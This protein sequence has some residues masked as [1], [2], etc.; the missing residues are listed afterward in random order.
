M[1]A[2]IGAEPDCGRFGNK[3]QGYC[4]DYPQPISQTES[5]TARISRNQP[6]LYSHCLPK[7]MAA[8]WKPAALRTDPRHPNRS[9]AEEILM[10]GRKAARTPGMQKVNS[11][12]LFRLVFCLLCV[13]AASRL[14]VERTHLF[15]RVPKTS[16]N[17][18]A[19]QGK[20]QNQ[21]APLWPSR[22]WFSANWFERVAEFDARQIPS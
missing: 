19:A 16:C 22:R 11:N 5:K 12:L 9:A 8:K 10:P 13:P 3:S 2:N 14:R 6:G 1:R 4:L 17:S 18:F 21:A 20:E 7:P 15:S